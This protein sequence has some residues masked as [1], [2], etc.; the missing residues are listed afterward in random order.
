MAPRLAG[1]DKSEARAQPASEVP[2]VQ[3]SPKTVMAG[4][5]REQLRELR[6]K[7]EANCDY[8]GDQ[9]AEEA[10]RIHY[11]EADARGIYGEATESQHDALVDEGIEVARIPWLPVNDA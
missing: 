7:G 2:A 9:F 1:S 11:G 10:R 3:N 6:Q 8:G 5:M 4:N